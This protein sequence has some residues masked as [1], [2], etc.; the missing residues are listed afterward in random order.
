MSS[1]VGHAHSHCELWWNTT[2][3]KCHTLTV[4]RWAGICSRKS[5]VEKTGKVDRQVR[6]YKSTAANVCYHMAFRKKSRFWL[7]PTGLPHSPRGR[8]WKH[9]E[10]GTLSDCDSAWQNMSPLAWSVFW[11]VPRDLSVFHTAIEPLDCSARSQHIQ[12]GLQYGHYLCNKWSR[13]RNMR[14]DCWSCL[15]N[16][17]DISTKRLLNVYCLQWSS[18]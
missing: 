18:R 8:R 11:T 9:R 7:L 2:I 15:V 17:W 12:S 16:Q 3:P 10:L 5:V 6:T 4:P 1:P 14:H 13:N